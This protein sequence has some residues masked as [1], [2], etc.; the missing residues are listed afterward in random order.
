MRNIFFALLVMVVTTLQAQDAKTLLKEA[1]NFERSLKEEPALEKYKQVLAIEPTNLLALTRS[2]ELS[3]GI[4][5][6]QTDKKQKR[7][8]YDAAKSFAERAL[9]VNA[10]SA[11]ANYV[12]ALVAG[13]LTET[14]TENKKIVAHVKDIKDY[15]D[16]AISIDPNHARAYYTLGK[17]HYEMVNLSWP[18]KAA[19]KV[20]FGG[21]PEGK[22]ED[23]F[24]YMEKSR[25]LDRYFVLTYLDLAKAYKSDNK[26]AKAIEVLNQLIKLPIR[27]AD[28]AALKEEG[29]KLLSEM[30]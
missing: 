30:Q 9:S 23:A 12:R 14:E 24:K 29:R 3:S 6:R 11:E 16:K 7:N 21:L 4:G 18:K 13:K 1:D 2:A 25:Q 26:P 20:L 22:I 27:T 19:I 15:A 8:Y 5:A 28:D 17:W 10:N